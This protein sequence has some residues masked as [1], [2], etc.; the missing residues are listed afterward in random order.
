MSYERSS[1]A[2]SYTHETIISTIDEMI[3]IEE[4]LEHD[5]D[6]MW[7]NPATERL[8]DSYFKKLEAKLVENVKKE[9]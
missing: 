8:L 4:L 9:L 7:I 6:L 2:N 5:K 3:R 1:V